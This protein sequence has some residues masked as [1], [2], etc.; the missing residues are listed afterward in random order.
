MSFSGLIAQ[1]IEI[2]FGAAA[3]VIAAGADGAK[4]S[5]GFT[6]RIFDSV[7]STGSAATPRETVRTK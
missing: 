2:V 7:L 3:T 6:F 4:V 1:K 5:T